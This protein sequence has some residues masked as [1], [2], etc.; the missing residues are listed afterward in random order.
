MNAVLAE[1]T[2]EARA[3]LDALYGAM[4][5]H[6]L[7]V[8]AGTDGQLIR[9]L[10]AM[11]GA[12]A[13]GI[14][15][16]ARFWAAAGAVQLAHEAS[17]LHDDVIDEST[18]RRSEP[19]LV[20]ARGVAVA[21][22]EGVHVLTTSYRL[23]AT[24]GSGVAA[25]FAHAVE[26]TVAG[27]KLQGRATGM[28]LDEASYRRIIAGKSGE[29][30]GFALA[31]AAY[32]ADH[33]AA[34]SLYVLGRR[35]G[36]L[37]QM[38]DD[39]LDYCPEA[40]TGK[41]PLADFSRKRW[42]WPLLELGSV[43]F[44]E[45]AAHVAA[46]LAAPDASGQSP[47]R[48]CLARFERE[49]DVVRAALAVHL[50]CDSV[51][52]ALVRGWGERAAEAVAC[53]ERAA[54]LRT[55]RAEVEARIP[56][57]AA[58]HAFFR[59]NS[60]TFS[61][62]ARA[63][64]REFRDRVTDVYAFCRVT[65]DLADDTCL[66]TDADD[67]AARLRRLDLWQALARQAHAGAPTGIGLLDRVMR[68][69]AVAGVPFQYVEEL[70]EGMRMDLR[71]QRY[72]TL[73]ELRVYTYRVAGVIGQWLTIMAGVRDP[74]VLERAAD[75]GHALQLTN[76]LRD[77][78][79]DLHAGRLYL[80]TG[81][82]ASS[83]V[84]VRML[85]GM[86]A[87][88]PVSDGYR[89][90]LEQLMYHADE[91][92]ARALHATAALP[93]WFRYAVRIAAHVY[94]GIHDEIRSAGHDNMRRRAQTS[95]TRKLQLCC[96]GLAARGVSVRDSD[97]TPR[98]TVPTAPEY[99]RAA[100]RRT[101]T[102]AF[103]LLFTA[104]AAHVTHVPAQQPDVTTHV[105]STAA[106]VAAQPEDVGARLDLVRALFFA[107]VD[108]EHAVERGHAAIADLRER[109]PTAAARHQALLLG[110][111][112]A[113]RALEA[114][115]GFWPHA[116]LRAV[117]RGLALL[118][119]AVAAAPQHLEIRYLRMVTSFYL[120]AL[121]GRSD[122]AREDL[123]VIEQLLSASAS[124]YPPEIFRVMADFVIEHGSP[125]AASE[126]RH[127]LSADAEGRS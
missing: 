82:M 123:R 102:A 71:G 21:L 28:V 12:E 98:V 109:M 53:V 108:E 22:V 8:P 38:L 96:R 15:Q 69:A 86:Q 24:C 100:R 62:A 106:R 85:Q 37:Y 54:L 105:A 63:F 97:T 10:L 64:P 77:T 1:R 104:A 41:P 101:R 14:E 39:L 7:G 58:L 79:E 66:P 120:P 83:G 30:L 5:P 11:A 75:L 73:A 43:D 61:F 52:N 115:H 119:A 42:T 67:R 95:A 4:R 126:L 44:A 45:P 26:R 76:I 127:M 57:D 111:E 18:L 60:R 16:D 107:A 88:A 81:L 70:I 117:R 80:P 65:D 35:V 31:A 125:R 29:L 36:E 92:Y 50:P 40:D 47:L 56:D 112:G 72:T 74:D 9:P 91:H 113:F 51:V 68:D 84:D 23:A 46:H 118:D 19:T 2:R 122:A 17:L 114:K 78:G 94:R 124:D 6:G 90:L 33:P 49:I 34:A 3:A 121:F 48:R 59:T 32:V 99:A 116:R 103:A 93:H 27:E 20:A 89:A 110:Y 55:T 87:G 25:A 13:L